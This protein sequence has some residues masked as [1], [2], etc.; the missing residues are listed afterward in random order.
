MKLLILI[1][2]CLLVCGFAPQPPGKK[3]KKPKKDKGADTKIELE[4]IKSDLD[5]LK[6][7]L[8]ELGEDLQN[9]QTQL[10]ETLKS[11]ENKLDEK[12]CIWRLGM[13]INPSDG[14]I[15]GYIVGK[16]RKSKFTQPRTENAHYQ[17][18]T[19]AHFY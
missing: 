9:G 13:N 18:S 2:L 3:P 4:E 8:I 14:H 12:T 17:Q 11:V 16:I 19:P 6:K 5:E 1:F 7:Q 10:E 15:F